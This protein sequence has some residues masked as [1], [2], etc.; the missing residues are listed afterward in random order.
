VEVYFVDSFR[1]CVCV[2]RTFRQN[3]IFVCAGTWQKGSTVHATWY[4]TWNEVQCTPHGTTH[5]MKYSPLHMV[6][7][8]KWSTV[9]STWYYTWNEVQSTPHGY[10]TWNDVQNF[11]QSLALT[12]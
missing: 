1:L 3:L 2:V 6:L 11:I 7:H 5:E 9:H 8:M 10:Y 12:I 4:Y